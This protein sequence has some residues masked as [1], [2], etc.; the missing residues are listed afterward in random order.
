MYVVEFVF[1]GIKNKL[2]EAASLGMAIVCSPQAC[3]GLR[4][5]ETP[6]FIQVRQ[7]DE[8]AGAVQRLWRDPAQRRRL[9]QDARQWVLERH[10]WQAAARDA[11]AGLS[12][13][14]RRQ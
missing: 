4:V 14:V 2:L 3:G 11:L 9:G 5:P 6:P 10:T 12:E 7:P 8:W 1:R 13:T